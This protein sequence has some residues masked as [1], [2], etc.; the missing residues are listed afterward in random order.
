MIKCVFVSCLMGMMFACKASVCVPKLLQKNELTAYIV[1]SHETLLAQN[2]VALAS[3]DKLAA[4]RAPYPNVSLKSGSMDLHNG[5][6]PGSPLNKRIDKGVGLDMTYERGNKR[7][8][9][10]QNAEDL[11]KAAEFDREDSGVTQEMNATAAYFDLAAAQARRTQLSLLADSAKAFADLNNSRLKLGDISAQDAARADIEYQKALVD[12][13][14]ADLE[15][16]RASVALSAIINAVACPASW[17]AEQSWAS[18]A[19]AGE[20]YHLQERPDIRAAH[21]RVQASDSGVAVAEAQK[22]ADISYG[23]SYDHFPGNSKALIELRV[24]MPLQGLK[25]LG[26]YQQE[27]EIARA[28]ALKTQAQIMR[29]RQ[30]HLATLEK[31]KYEQER[32][33]LAAK[34]SRYQTLIMPAQEQVV[35]IAEQAYRLGGIALTELLET[36]RQLRTLA[37]DTLNTQAELAKL[38][39]LAHLRFTTKTARK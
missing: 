29:D 24:S 22:L 21:A 15:I 28:Q 12:V 36:K 32:S 16:E 10:T 17:V 25:W 30:V 33:A 8:L 35:R 18:T 26:G 19:V 23:V 31:I 20:G 34:L 6:G 39:A 38:D 3:A 7:A 5:L 11:I 1:R 9:R 14:Q 13:T 37:L 2:A 4:D 27:G